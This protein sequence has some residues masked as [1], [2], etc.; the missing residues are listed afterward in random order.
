MKLRSQH[1]FQQRE[2]QSGR[3]TINRKL[4]ETVGTEK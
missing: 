2:E 1:I 4:N 3:A